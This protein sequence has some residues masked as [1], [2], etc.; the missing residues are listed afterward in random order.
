MQEHLAR[1]GAVAAVVGAVMLLVGTLLHPIEADPNEAVEAF[2]EYAADRIWILSHLTQ[3]VGVVALGAALVALAGIMDTGRAAAW[4]RIGA[5]GAA[6]AVAAGAALQAV[7]GVALK[8]V[9]DRWAAASGESRALAFEAAFAVR[10]VEIGLASLFSVLFGLTAL[11]FSVSICF[12]RRF[13]NW[14]G[15]VGLIGGQGLSLAVLRNPIRASRHWR[16]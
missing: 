11:A 7:D 5:F 3:F 12:S 10:Q 2:T 4:A 1:I 15:A 8:V 6:S 16:W 9:A 13:A 14:L